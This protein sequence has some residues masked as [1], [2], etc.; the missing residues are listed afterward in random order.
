[1]ILFT[2]LYRTTVGF[3]CSK[4]KGSGLKSQIKPKISFTEW[5]VNVYDLLPK[6]SCKVKINTLRKIYTNSKIT[7]HI[8]L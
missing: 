8:E 3:T 6:T 7:D 2:K 5:L 4:F 1:M